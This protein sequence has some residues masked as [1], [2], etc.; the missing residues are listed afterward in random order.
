MSS[1]SRP[2]FYFLGI[3]PG[4]AGGLALI[5]DLGRLVEVVNS[6]ETL[7]LR[8]DLLSGWDDLYPIRLAALER[9]H[10]AAHTFKAKKDGSRVR[11]SAQG[12]FTFG[13]DFGAWSAML[14]MLKIPFI[15]PT[16]VQWQKRVIGPRP[17]RQIKGDSDIKRWVAE[18][19]SRRW[20]GA[21]IYGPRGGLLDGLSDALALA[22]YA[23][24]EIF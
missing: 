11:M 1:E 14:T 4:K 17:K 15:L 5:D 22:E 9:V 12:A 23:R 3:D 18:F 6:P 24:K 7:S 13:A 21:P 8:A 20:P 2:Q 19:V 10:G 16:P